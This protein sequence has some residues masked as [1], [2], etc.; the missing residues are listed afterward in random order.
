MAVREPLPPACESLAPEEQE[1]FRALQAE[2]GSDDLRYSRNCQLKTF[3]HALARVFRF[4]HMAPTNLPRRYRACG[5]CEISSGFAVNTKALAR[6]LRKS[7]SSVNSM[8]VGIGFAS[9]P[10]SDADIRELK[11]KIDCAEAAVLRNWTVRRWKRPGATGSA[12]DAEIPNP[13][14]DESAGSEW[15]MADGWWSAFQ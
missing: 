4:C 6:I 1:A 10:P 14:P 13:E 12:T 5:I 3:A 9:A 8:F 11:S 2:V 15:E 7:K